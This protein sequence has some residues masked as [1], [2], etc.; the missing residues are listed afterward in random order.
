MKEN[1]S[2]D[3]PFRGIRIRAGTGA[4]CSSVGSVVDTLFAS[5]AA[6]TA[7]LAMVL[8]ALRREVGEEDT[9]K[10]EGPPPRKEMD[11]PRGDE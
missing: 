10:I 3:D 11:V 7:L 1:L 5:A 6:G 8:V 4:N 2:S 9:P